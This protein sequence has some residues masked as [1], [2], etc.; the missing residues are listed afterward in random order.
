MLLGR[1]HDDDDNLRHDILVFERI[2]REQRKATMQVRDVTAESD[3]PS[4]E[5]KRTH[6]NDAAKDTPKAA[7]SP[8]PGAASE[9]G[10]AK[11]DEAT[12]VKEE[13]A[14]PEPRGETTPER[15]EDEVPEFG[16]KASEEATRKVETAQKEAE[17][18]SGA[19]PVGADEITDHAPKH[20]GGE[21]AATATEAEPEAADENKKSLEAAE[22]SV[23]L[24]AG[25]ES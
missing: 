6:E 5:P 12:A 20:Q 7:T 23:K 16:D 2:K 21:E 1:T 22:E 8:E 14:L 11:A 10:I 18:P 19:P 13:V 4:K 15:L 25:T 24:A 9:E 17:E 3:T